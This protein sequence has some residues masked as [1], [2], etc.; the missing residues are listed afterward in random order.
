MRN[1][2]SSAVE[3]KEAVASTSQVHVED[4][5]QSTATPTEDLNSNSKEEAMERRKEKMQELRKKMADSTKANRKAVAGETNRHK[6]SNRIKPTTARKLERAE[7]L[8]DERDAVERGEDFERTRSWKY[9]I[10]E[11]DKWEEKLQEKEAKKD[12]GYLDAQSASERTYN[13]L[14][15]Q[16]KP[17]RNKSNINAQES[18]SELIQDKGL[19]YGTHKPDDAALD[20]VAAHLNAE[21]DV[22]SKRSRQRAE[23][24]DAGVDYIN[25]KN[26]HY[27]KKIKRFF[28]QHVGE[29]RDSFERGTAL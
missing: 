5:Q 9:T 16:I 25:N 13:R 27:N 12:Q 10:E 6:Q 1:T 11:N 20:R 18:S 23:D 24:P 19:Q 17:D 14:I 21:A 29:I 28:D 22:R 8:L 26:K 15:G 2:R 3:A 4:E 7:R